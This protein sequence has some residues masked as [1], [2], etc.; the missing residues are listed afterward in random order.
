MG[1]PFIICADF[2]SLLEKISTCHN[3]PNESSTT[4]INKH[5]ASDYSLFTHCSFDATK[6]K[7]DCYRDQDCM[8]E[9][10]KHLNKH[11][12]KIINSEKKKR[13]YTFNR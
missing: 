9:F 11:A 1:V 8:K 10:C 12:M 13:N 3:N 7:L 2:E 6:N 4:K 5:K